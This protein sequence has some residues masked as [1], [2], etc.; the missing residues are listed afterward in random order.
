MGVLMCPRPVRRGSAPGHR[1]QEEQLDFDFIESSKR[2]RDRCRESGQPVSRA[3]FSFVLRGLLMRGH[4]FGGGDDNADALS[5]KLADNVRS[6]CLRE[7][8]L[9]DDA[10]DRTIRR[11]ITWG[12]SGS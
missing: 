8:I 1:R 5:R 7:Q 12:A 2:I 11:W 10:T 6:L 9:L 4:S 3:D